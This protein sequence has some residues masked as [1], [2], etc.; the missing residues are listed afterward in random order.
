MSDNNGHNNSIMIALYP[1]QEVAEALRLPDGELLEDLHVTLLYLGGVD[2]F[3]P[4]DVSALPELINNFCTT[5]DNDPTV[6][7]GCIGG[8]G[9]FLP[10]PS[11]DGQKPLIA[12]IDVPGLEHFRH[13]LCNT[14]ENN[15]YAWRNNHGFTPHLTLKYTDD[16]SEHLEN[17]ENLPLNFNELHLVIANEHFIYPIGSELTVNGMKYFATK[18]SMSDFQMNERVV[19]VGKPEKGVGTVIN[20]E[21]NHVAVEWKDGSIELYPPIWLDGSQ[22]MATMQDKFGNPLEESDNV[23]VKFPDDTVAPGQIENINN[24]NEGREKAI[25]DFDNSVDYDQDGGFESYDVLKT[26]SSSSNIKLSKIVHEDGKWTV[27]S[28][29][30]KKN[31]GTYDTKED[32]L[33]RLKDVE[34]FKHKESMAQDDSLAL[35]AQFDDIGIV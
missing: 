24:D 34:Y 25:M 17:I 32:A 18:R 11:S 20:L 8:L 33:D 12:L 23:I 21:G 35:F 5:Y 13:Y 26:S 6:L 10:S 3:D 14:L 2:E 31:L 28:H 9:E 1:N 7:Q 29:D 30:G 19:A 22:K 4:M 27:Q 15:D 16:P